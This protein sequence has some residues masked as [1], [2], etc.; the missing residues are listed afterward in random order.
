MF[1][2]EIGDKTFILTMIT[3]NELGGCATFVTAFVTLCAMHILASTLGWGIAFVIH[4]FWTKLVCTILFLVI[5][6]VMFIFACY[7]RHPH[8]SDA[9]LGKAGHSV[10]LTTKT[11]EI[12]EVAA[13]NQ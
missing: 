4:E 3:Y 6:I 7:D 13:D 9:A 11:T 10:T 5:A 8:S 2:A 1:L 12:K